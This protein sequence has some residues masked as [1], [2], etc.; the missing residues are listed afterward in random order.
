MFFIKTT[1]LINGLECLIYSFL[2]IGSLAYLWDVFTLFD[3]KE[4]SMKV[5]EV[6]IKEQPTI[7]ITTSEDNGQFGRHIDELHDIKLTYSTY[8]AWDGVNSNRYKRTFHSMEN[9]KVIKFA[10][11]YSGLNWIIFL[12]LMI[13]ISIQILCYTFTGVC[14]KLTF[15][16]P[17][18]IDMLSTIELKLNESNLETLPHISVYL[19]SEENSDGIMFYSW[20]DGQEKKLRLHKEWSNNHVWMTLFPEKFNHLKITSNCSDMPSYQQFGLK[21]KDV[22]NHLNCT[23]KCL[24]RSLLSVIPITDQDMIPICMTKQQEKCAFVATDQFLKFSE[25]QKPCSVYQYS[26]DFEYWNQE[27]DGRKKDNNTFSFGWWFPTPGTVKVQEEFLIY[28]TIALTSAIASTLG[29]FIGFSFSGIVGF[30]FRILK[31]KVD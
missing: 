27:A 26:G 29:M 12:S 1:K 15:A 22:M 21:L 19:T 23:K 31:S 16:N 3:A 10:T 6:Q 13:Y 2:L 14:L 30:T 24:P 20:N 17:I 7:I 25:Y 4:T 11:K 18:L 28:D 8:S 9:Y 5:K